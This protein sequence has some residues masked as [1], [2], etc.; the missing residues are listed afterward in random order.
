MIG[1]RVLRK[2]DMKLGGELGQGCLGGAGEN[3]E[4]TDKNTLYTCLKFSKNK[5]KKETLFK[6]INYLKKC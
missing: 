1:L 2:A 3:R 6:K 5:F 4:L